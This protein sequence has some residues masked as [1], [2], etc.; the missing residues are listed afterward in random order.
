MT[1]TLRY[2]AE[3]LEDFD[4]IYDYLIEYDIDTAERALRA[5]S[6]GLGILVDFPFSCRRADGGTSVMREL[7]VPFGSSGYVVLFR[8]DGPETV[9]I[10]AVRH[11]R[12]DDY[13]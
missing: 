3:A 7:L 1:Y 10:A 5:T 13:H 6:A 2:A 4:R 9:T 8:I 11:Q 12:E